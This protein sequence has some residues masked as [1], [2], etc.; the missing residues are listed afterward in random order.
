MVGSMF[1][2]LAFTFV[3]ILLTPHLAG[4]Q[5]TASHPLLG[6]WQAR[7]Q[8]IDQSY[9]IDTWSFGANEAQ[10]DIQV[11]NTNNRALSLRDVALYAFKYEAPGAKPNEHYFVISLSKRIIT[12][13]TETIAAAFNSQKYCDLEN[14]EVGVENDVTS[15]NCAWVGSWFSIAKIE[16][17][18]LDIAF[19]NDEEICQTP[20][21]RCT[22]FYGNKYYKMK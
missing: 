15:T 1:K 8:V 5:S 10:Y 3:T 19:S 9:Q 16:N 11:Y 7:M 12:P 13:S 17:G 22:K 14:W 20:E 4:D 21:D 2:S 18:I 6:H